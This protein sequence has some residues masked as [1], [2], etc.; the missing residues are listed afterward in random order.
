[1]HIVIDNNFKQTYTLYYENLREE[2]LLKAINDVFSRHDAELVVDTVNIIKTSMTLGY[3]YTRCYEEVVERIKNKFP[4]E[5]DIDKFIFSIALRIIIASGSD[6]VYNLISTDRNI[7]AEVASK[8]FK[9]PPRK[10]TQEMIDEIKKVS[11]TNEDLSYSITDPPVNSW[12]EYFYSVCRQV[13]RNSKCLSRRI[14]AVLV[15]DKS[16]VSTGYNGPPRGVPRCDMQWKTNKTFINKY[17]HILKSKGITIEDALGKCPRKVLGCKS[18][19]GLDICVATH[20]EVNAVVN[21][22]RLGVPTIGTTLYLTC[23]IPC[24][25]CMQVIINAGIKDIVITSLMTYDDQALYLIN[26]SDVSIRLFNL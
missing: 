12:D 15:K 25:N 3:T 23:A 8:Y 16:I 5:E 1:M 4:T 19:E 26:N 7:E 2:D 20:S 22:A 9:V 14:G 18:G 11:I 24:H 21:A 13:A 6:D 17:G 10:V